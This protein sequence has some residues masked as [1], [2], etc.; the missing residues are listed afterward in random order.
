MGRAYVSQIFQRMQMQIWVFYIEIWKSAP[1][2]SKI[3]VISLKDIKRI[4][5]IQ[6]R[7]AR[8]V[9]NNYLWLTSV[10]GLINDLK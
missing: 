6:K 2:S 7:A 3:L 9:K 4:V 5:K 8:F 10:T 1:L